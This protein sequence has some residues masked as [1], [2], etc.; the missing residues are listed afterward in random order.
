MRRHDPG[1]PGG[2]V[3]AGEPPEWK[4]VVVTKDHKYFRLDA[5][6]EAPTWVLLL[7]VLALTIAVI[8]SAVAG[9]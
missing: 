2:R 6:L 9:L 4:R 1:E 8:A 5:V 7:L 3:R